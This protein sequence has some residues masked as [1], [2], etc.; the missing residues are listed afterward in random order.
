MSAEQPPT[1]RPSQ[2]AITQ[3]LA[4]MESKRRRAAR[5]WLLALLAPLALGIA[6][7]AYMSYAVSAR[8]AELKRLNAEVRA[9]EARLAEVLRRKEESQKQLTSGLS[10]ALADKP[11]EE[12]KKILDKLTTNPV[13][14]ETIP[15]VFI[16]YYEKDPKTRAAQAGRAIQQLGYIVPGSEALQRVPNDAQV[17]YFFDGDRDAAQKV[18]DVLGAQGV[19]NVRVLKRGESARPGLIE[20]WLPPLAKPLAHGGAAVGPTPDTKPDAEKARP[21]ATKPSAPKPYNSP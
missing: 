19:A 8:Y 14:A 18:A 10:E 15:R 20:V 13:V 9:E 11:P 4:E 7:L 6:L 16:H 21:E 17:R 3:M 2:L 12:K 1:V 5:R